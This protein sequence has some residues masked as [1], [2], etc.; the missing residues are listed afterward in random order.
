[1]TGVN[2]QW[3]RNEYGASLI[4]LVS[5]VGLAFIVT[6]AA[7]L[8]AASD[9]EN[10]AR[11]AS[12]KVDIATREE[13]LMGVLVRQT[14]TGML[15]GA[16]GVTGTPQPWTTI[17]TDAMNQLSA[18]S[19]VDPAE[20]AALP[21]LTGVIPANMGDTAGTLLG[22]FRG[23]HHE[24]PFGGTSG[25]ANL[26]PSYDATVQPPLMN[27]SGNAPLSSGDALTT[28]QEFFLGSMY[29]SL[30]PLWPSLDQ[31]S[32]SNRWGRIT[33]PNIGFGYQQPG[34][35][36]FIARRVW[37]R[38]PLV[39]QTTPQTAADQAGVSH[40]PSAQAN[41]ILSVYEI[42]SQLPISGNANLKIG[43]N[44]DGAAW[45]NG[46][47]GAAPVPVAGN[48][49]KVMVVPVMSGNQFYMAAP[50]TPTHW[51]L[52]ARP[53]YRCRIRIIISGTDSALIYRP[54]ATPQINS[55]AGAIS[56]KVIVLPDRSSQPDQILG[57][58]DRGGTT[59]TQTSCAGGDLPAYMT[60]TSTDMGTALNRNILVINVGAMVTA[61]G[62]PA[63][64]Y[65]IYVGSNPT[66]EP[67]SPARV[68]D[69]GVAITGTSDL[70][71]FTAGLSIVTNQTL[72]LLDSF[73]Q[74]TTRPATS[75]YAPDVRYGI[76]GVDPDATTF[77]GQI[78]VD[79]A[80]TSNSIGGPLRFVDAAG[81]SI[82]TSSASNQLAL[83]KITNSTVQQVPPITRLTLLFTIDKERTN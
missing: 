5:I 9:G 80:S 61:L 77:T 16:D 79:P 42:P 39:Y 55:A 45:G 19:H 20:L 74:G 27:W 34:D 43:F 33:Y 7:F 32:A 25:L 58:P 81:N 78:G 83:K 12:A 47:K 60:Y 52:Y 57:V 17:M 67:V 76:S 13:E 68:S 21:G 66:S 26:V 35:L 73:N 49:G 29:T 70:H 18:T 50:G 28:P 22:N 63:Q 62:N 59:Y 31:L 3:K 56:V 54:S 14:A 46:F 37:W 75:I 11:L 64:L 72:Y 44:A 10:T 36:N 6:V 65:S 8:V 15:P 51:D 30:S 2:L 41:F 71:L 23:Y 82:S 53:Y 1:M 38:I 48:R 24:V 40:Y 4:L 69:P